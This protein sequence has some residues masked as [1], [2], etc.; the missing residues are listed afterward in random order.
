MNWASRR[1]LIYLLI[2]VIA[3]VLFIVTPAAYVLYTPPSCT[4]KKQNQGELGVDCGGPCATLCQNLALEPIISWQRVFK[5]TDGYYN[6]IA[7][8]ENPNIGS[9]AKNVAYMFRVYDDK[10]VLIVERK[11]R[12]TLL[13]NSKFPLFEPNLQTGKRIPARV[14]FEFTG[15]PYWERTTYKAPAVRVTSRVLKQPQS[16]RLEATIANDTPNDLRNIPV[17]A[18]IYDT[19]GNALAASRTLLEDIPGNSSVLAV[20][21]WPQA[22]TG[23][24]SQR[25]VW[26]DLR[27]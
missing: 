12:T 21:T 8:I 2:A 10:N 26:I 27:Q 4:D 19:E 22:F 23:T 24:P 20:F 25:E 14:T 1:K 15:T 7:Y 11:G 18:I 13:P 9:T 5:I 6:A 17:I 3:V 16:P